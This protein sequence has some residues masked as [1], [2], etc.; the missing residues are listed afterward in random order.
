MR[1]QG[2]CTKNRF[3]A[4]YR[5]RRIFSPGLHGLSRRS[6]VLLLR[7]SIT[8]P[9]PGLTLHPPKRRRMPARIIVFH[10]EANEVG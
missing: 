10:K 7:S 1:A 3:Q 8:R 6:C 5:S 9:A 4:S 2:E